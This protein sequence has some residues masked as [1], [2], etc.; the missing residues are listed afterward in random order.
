M[1]DFIYTH[2]VGELWRIIKTKK[3]LKGREGLCIYANREV[4]IH[5]ELHGK[6]ALIAIL[7]EFLHIF[8]SNWTED[9]IDSMAI[10][11]G[12]AMW[13]MNVRIIEE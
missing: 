7:H 11:L 5:P 6:A 1:N 4:R 12:E 2:F 10:E 9:A 8:L 3:D 13:K